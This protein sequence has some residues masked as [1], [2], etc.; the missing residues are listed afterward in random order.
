[1]D[2]DRALQTIE[3]GRSIADLS[4][5]LK[6]WRGESGLAHLV[7]HATHIPAA[8]QPNPVLLL[9]YDDAW[10]N[11]YV[12]EDYFRIDP[13]VL[14]GRTGFRPIDWM[15]LDHQTAA[16]RHFFA[17]AESYGVGRHGFTLPIRGPY[18]ERALFTIT[19]NET[20][21]HWVRWR[22][23]H[24]RDFYLLAHYFH[25]RV[26]Q[27]AKL[28]PEALALSPRETH[29]LEQIGYGRTPQQI[30]GGLT[31]TVGAVHQYLR[32]ARKKLACSTLEESIAKAV[33][34]EVI[35][36]GNRPI[37]EI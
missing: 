33:C 14:A 3:Q 11:H 6:D 36:Y 23:D 8:S 12:A 20:D 4:V 34:L 18:G 22:Y 30:A 26:M 27:I 5:A 2:L 17:K 10:V 32:S 25:D 35:D 29:C 31:I 9:T 37:P 16:A 7:Y 28:R 24:L 1:M 13:V 21:H 19:S 15:S